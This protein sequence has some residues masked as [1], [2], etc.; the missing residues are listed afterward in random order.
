[1]NFLLYNHISQDIYNNFC[2]VIYVIFLEKRLESKIE[3]TINCLMGID[4]YKFYSNFPHRLV[5]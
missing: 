1:M 4:I 2:D 5:C 3:E